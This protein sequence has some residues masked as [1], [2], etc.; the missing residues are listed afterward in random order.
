M[1]KIWLVKLN[2]AMKAQGKKA[3]TLSMA[4]GLN[5]T[6]VR[7]LTTR[8][9]EPT[10]AKLEA[11]ANQLGLPMSYFF[12]QNAPIPQIAVRGYASGG[13]EWTPIDDH[14]KEDGIELISM[15]IA[16]P[17]SIAIRVRGTSM[18]PV[19]RDGDDLICTPQWGL[20]IASVLGKDC[21]VKTLDQRCYIKQVFKGSVKNTYRLRSYNQSYPDIEDVA[22]EWAAPVLWIRRSMS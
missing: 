9:V 12:D 1:K 21:V 7:D 15:D 16:A 13:E 22:I 2:E 19:F 10:V 17:D 4:A 20:N 5:E 14:Q 11:I 18:V 3:K 6:Y 8:G